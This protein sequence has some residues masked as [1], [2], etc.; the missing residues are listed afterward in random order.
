MKARHQHNQAKTRK[1][2]ISWTDPTVT[3]EVELAK[4]PKTKVTC[5]ACENYAAS[6]ASK[7]V[8]VMC[9]EGGCARGEIARRAAN[10]LCFKLAPDKTARI[11]L[12]GAFTKN[13]GQRKL[14]REARRLIAIEGCFIRCATRMMAGVVPD[15]K[16]EVV[17]ADDHYDLDPI[18]FGINEL[19]NHDAN[20]CALQ[21]ARKIAGIL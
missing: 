14:V 13:T 1:A 7:P 15:L 18:P 20:R 5:Q 17:V 2:L 8:T 12:G 4:I 3:P 11:C 16:P 19:S 9:C 21:L 10:I 6:Q